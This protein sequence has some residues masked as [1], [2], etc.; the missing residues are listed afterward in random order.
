MLRTQRETFLQISFYALFA[1]VLFVIGK[2]AWTEYTLTTTHDVCNATW[3]A[4][5]V[6]SPLGSLATLHLP[7]AAL[8]PQVVHL[9][10]DVLPIS[11]HASSGSSRVGKCTVMHGKYG[12]GRSPAF[13][14]HL[15]HSEIHHYPVFVLDRPLL[16]GL[17]SKEA[18]LLAVLLHEMTKP[19]D[20][21]LQ[22]LMGKFQDRYSVT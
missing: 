8:A 4:R 19:E 9:G 11:N 1:C 18:A 13:D 5:S 16:D 7:F 3:T 14:T 10:S 6:P 17:W 12:T 15:R 22:W 21:R 2:E 20:A